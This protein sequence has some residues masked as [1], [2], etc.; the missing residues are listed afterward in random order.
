MTDR[1]PGGGGRT[2]EIRATAVVNATGAWADGLRAPVGGAP[3]LR[4][5]RGSHLLF[6]AW[7]LPV[8]QAVSYAH[9]ADGRPV[10]AYPWETVT[11]VGTTDVDHPDDLDAGA[12]ISPG[13]GG[14]P[15]GVGARTSSRRSTCGR[16]TSTRPSPAS[17]P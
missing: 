1:A 3:R 16:P 6:P 8:A 17:G 13:G 4:P 2:A 10:F 14:L 5:L 15:A 11:L 7:R 12:R 9:P